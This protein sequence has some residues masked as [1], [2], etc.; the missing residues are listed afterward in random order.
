MSVMS[1][2]R[3]LCSIQVC[4]ER[5]DVCYERSD[6]CYDQVSRVMNDLKSVMTK[7]RLLPTKFVRYKPINL[8]T[9]SSDCQPSPCLP[10]CLSGLHPTL[11][12]L[13]ASRTFAANV[14][15]AVCPLQGRLQQMFSSLKAI[16]PIA[17]GANP[18]SDNK[19]CF[20]PERN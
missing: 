12:N 2:L 3:P 8:Q 17:S 6:V 19:I 14:F 1:K 18:T 5:S 4:Y 20:V 15:I 16:Y 7:F 9:N 13:S 11:S 10:V